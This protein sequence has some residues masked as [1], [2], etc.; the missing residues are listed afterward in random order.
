MIVVDCTVVVDALT[1]VGGT[2]DLRALLSAEQL[3][4]PSLLD[5]EVVSVLRSLTSRGALTAP[6]AFDVLTDFD[7]LRIRRWPSSDGMRRRSLQLRDNVSAHDAA[8]LA[9]A[10]ALECPL[11]TRDLRLA[12]T[13]GHDVTVEVR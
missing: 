10:E 12:R 4:A 8:Y 3:A 5:H 6:R 2:D 9:L 7:N 1:G 13:I 11:V